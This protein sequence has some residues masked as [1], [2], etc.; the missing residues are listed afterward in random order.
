MRGERNTDRSVRKFITI[1]DTELWEKTEKCFG[2]RARLRGRQNFRT[3]FR[4]FRT[5]FGRFRI[6]QRQSQA[7]YPPILPVWMKRQRGAVKFPDGFRRYGRGQLPCQEVWT[8]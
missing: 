5:S 6:R 4:N 8:L 1:R 3:R 2:A 7:E